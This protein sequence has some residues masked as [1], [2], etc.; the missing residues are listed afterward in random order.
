MD[1]SEKIAFYDTLFPFAGIVFII[2]IGVVVLYQQFQKVL[3]K[4]ELKQEALKNAHQ[5]EL[6]RS[7]IHTQEKERERIAQDLHDELGAILS[8][9]QMH[10]A[11]I[12]KLKF[13]SEKDLQ[14]SVRMVKGMIDGALTSTRRIS[15]ELMPAQLLAMGWVAAIKDIAQK[16]NVSSE[17]KVSVEIERTLEE[18]SWPIKVGLY[19]I[20]SELINNTIKHANATESSI[21]ICLVGTTIIGRY[22]DNGIGLSKSSEWDKGLG[23]KGIESRTSALGGNLVFSKE[24]KEGFYIKIELPYQKD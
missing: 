3:V 14:Q 18:L 15:H 5:Q 21:E 13:K 23:L 4:E 16:A 10:L 11:Q 19:R 8:I 24:I 22:A 7:S 17:L 9:S 20:Y 1:L 6:L 2:A 12:E